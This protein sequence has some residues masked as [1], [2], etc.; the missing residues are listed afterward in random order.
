MQAVT[1]LMKLVVYNGASMIMSCVFFTS[2]KSVV[3]WDVLAR[4]PD[5]IGLNVVVAQT[6]VGCLAFIGFLSL[7]EDMFEVQSL[8]G[9]C[10]QPLTCSL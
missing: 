8:L 7:Y 6:F 2:V 3:F 9:I 1:S 4:L 5:R 10:T